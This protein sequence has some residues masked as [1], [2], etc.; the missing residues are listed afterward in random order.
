[1]RGSGLRD[2]L[3]PQVF[4][5]GTRGGQRGYDGAMDTSG[6]TACRLIADLQLVPH[7]EGGH[8]RRVYESALPVE[9]GG[10]RRPAL[11]AI[12]F[13][14]AEG[15]ASRWHRVDADETW[16]WQDG[17]PL[18]LQ[19]FDADDGVLRT[20]RLDSAARG[21]PAM[22]VVRAGRWQAA[23]PLSAYTLV[24]CTVAPG[25]VWDGF[26]LLDPASAVAQAL[27]EAGAWS[28]T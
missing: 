11:T 26:A 18:E 17:G 15:E 9:H 25:F 3:V 23:R 2:R 22:H 8:Y 21:G 19:E 12:Q 7:P 1:M 14:L 27:R 4:R 10:Y 5:L 24:A 13:L 20:I 28:P 16:H 6:P